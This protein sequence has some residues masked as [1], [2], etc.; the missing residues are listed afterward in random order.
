[1]KKKRSEA[2]QTL[3]AG[4]SKAEPKILSCLRSPSQG[5]GAAKI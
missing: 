1:M 5:P 3:C 4:F 2:T